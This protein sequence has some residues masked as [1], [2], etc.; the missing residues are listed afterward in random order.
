M[1]MQCL[2]LTYKNVMNCVSLQYALTK[3]TSKKNAE[4]ETLSERIVRCNTYK[5][6]VKT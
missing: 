6:I 2:K 3:Q 5:D 4:G 1:L